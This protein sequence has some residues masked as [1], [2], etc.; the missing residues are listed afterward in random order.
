MRYFIMIEKEWGHFLTR[1]PE[2]KIPKD[3]R[4]ISPVRGYSKGINKIIFRSNQMMERT[5]LVEAGLRMYEQE[6]RTTGDADFLKLF[7]R[8]RR[9]DEYSKKRCI[10][11]A[12]QYVK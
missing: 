3:V 11:R 4:W 2:E 1:V 6:F 10:Q 7:K 9:Q 5:M 8:V 12:L